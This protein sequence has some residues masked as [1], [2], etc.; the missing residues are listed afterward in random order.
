MSNRSFAWLLGLAL[1]VGTVGCGPSG[2]ERRPRSADDEEKKEKTDAR[3]GPL[4]TVWD[5]TPEFKACY[6]EARRT[7]PDLVLKA[8]ID[9][10]VDGKGR[11]QRA[12][13]STAKPIDESLKKCLVKVAESIAFSAS[14]DGFTVKPAI[15]FQP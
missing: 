10:S 14:G 4:R 2:P 8:T 13:V 12:F 5:H 7:S 6:D 3:F 9:I 11:V 15:V 1:V